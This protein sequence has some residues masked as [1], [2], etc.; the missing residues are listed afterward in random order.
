MKYAYKK[1][2]IRIYKSFVEHSVFN[3]FKVEKYELKII[4][5]LNILNLV[6]KE[7]ANRFKN[8]NNL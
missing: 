6:E 8:L 4:L 7:I 2:T 1:N 5:D 3:N